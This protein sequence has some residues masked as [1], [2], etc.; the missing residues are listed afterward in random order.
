KAL[1]GKPYITEQIQVL[2]NPGDRDEWQ[3]IDEIEFDCFISPEQYRGY[4]YNSYTLELE[5]VSDQAN[6]IP[7]AVTAIGNAPLWL[8]PDLENTFRHLSEYYQEIWAYILLAAEH[9]YIDEIAYSI[10]HT[11][12]A[13]LSEEN[14]Y[15]ADLFQE[16]AALIYEID[17]D[18]SY[19]EVV[20][21]GIAGLDPDYYTTTRYWKI[22]NLGNTVQ[23]E[24]PREIYYMYL[25]HPKNTDEIPAYIDP[26]IVEDNYWHDNN[27][28][29]PPT[30]VFWRNFLYNHND[31]GYPLLKDYLM[32]CAVVWDSATLSSSH[33]IGAI[34]TWLAESLTFTSNLERPHQP[35]RIYRKH[36]GRCGEHADMRSAAARAAL[37]P[38]TSIL[39]ISGDHTWNEF[40]DEDWIHWDSP[41]VNNPMVYE[42]GWGKVHASVFEIKSNGLLT[43]VTAKYSDGAAHIQIYVVDPDNQSVDGARIVL[44]VQDGVEILGDNVGYTGNDGMYDFEVGESRTYY[45]KMTS[46][47]GNIDDYQLLVENAVDGESYSFIFPVTGYM[48]DL[49]FNEI[50]VPEDN[51][52]DY[53]LTLD[54]T[55]SREITHGSI[56]FDDVPESGFFNGVENGQ[57]NFFMFDL[58]NFSSYFAGFNFE[59]FNVL[60]P[61]TGADL[62]F[63]MPVP[64]F[65]YWYALFDNSQFI[66]HPQHVTGTVSLYEF[67][68]TA[69]GGD[70]EPVFK[71][72]SYPNPCNPVTTI[73]F[74][75]STFS[76]VS[77]QIYNLKGEKVITLLDQDMLPGHHTMLW[78]PSGFNSGIYF[79]HLVHGDKSVTGKICLIK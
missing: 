79:Y 71:S 38:C 51:Q 25:V 17:N 39:T 47:L 3:L 21:Y 23:V 16:N 34:S 27:I 33:A 6:L 18:L 57:L 68:E 30:G 74:D 31:E 43:P 26:D 53:M 4:A 28:S 36:I 42:N 70:V 35:V 19:V 59:A 63:N 11:S 37:I 32:N 15:H 64:E 12:T 40:W 2:Y 69:T 7:D 46:E 8:Q 62:E 52:Q 76:R 56:V 60:Y 41:E 44:G 58:I 29:D 1:T 54:F 50:A 14:Y 20:D 9:P 67:V 75:L 66:N 45:A 72:G 49:D 48:P 55:V 5:T 24:V 65:G 10:A 77:L 73:Y 13:Y 61:G 78:E 22:D